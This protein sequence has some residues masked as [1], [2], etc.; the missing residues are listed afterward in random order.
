MQG[1]TIYFDNRPKIIATA[2]VAGPNETEGIVGKYVDL[3]LNNDMFNEE[4]YEKAERKM[5]AYA[6]EKSIQNANLAKEKVDLLISGDLL[7]QIISASFA[8]RQFGIPFLG[9]GETLAI[10]MVFVYAFL[11]IL[12]NTYTGISGIS[13]V[14]M[15]VA[16]GIGLTRMQQLRRV[17]LP[18]AMPYI[19]S[20]IR[21][22]AVS[23]VGTMTIAAF[24]GAN[25]LGSFIQLGMNSL[26]YPMTIMGAV[27]AALMA[28]TLDFLLGRVERAFTSEG[29]LPQDQI[30][31]LSLSVRSRRKAMAAALCGALLVVSV[32]SYASIIA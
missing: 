6:I 29:L 19:M 5:L 30:K 7:N 22:A 24:A 4:T 12:K 18:M 2:T 1:H 10:F 27:A 17:E 13:P 23:S 16:R 25:G 32:A 26:N 28:L 31:N 21:I 14:S 20:G 11:P 3:P 9:V 15:E 8:A